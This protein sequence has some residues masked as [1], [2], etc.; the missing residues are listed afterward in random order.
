[1]IPNPQ[2]P[3]GPQQP[4]RVAQNYPIDAKTCQCAVQGAA[5]LKFVDILKEVCDLIS[6]LVADA[7]RRNVSIPANEKLYFSIVTQWI[8]LGKLDL[9]E[10]MVGC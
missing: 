2:H 4:G 1:M 7:R 10:E 5:E 3:S 8:K 9:A 6:N